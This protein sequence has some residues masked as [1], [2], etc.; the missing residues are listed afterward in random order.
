MKKPDII[1]LMDGDGWAVLYAKGNKKVALELFNNELDDDKQITEN[2]IK[3]EKAY[4]CRFCGFYTIGE[5]ECCEC[6][7][8][9]GGREM[10]VFAYYN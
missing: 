2:D 1:S 9:I 3:E 8:G 7:R 4:C 6:D 10:S 5:R